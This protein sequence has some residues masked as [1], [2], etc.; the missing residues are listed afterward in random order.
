MGIIEDPPSGCWKEEEE[1]RNPHKAVNTE[2][3]MV[4]GNSVQ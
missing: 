4:Q 2:T 1:I 3:D